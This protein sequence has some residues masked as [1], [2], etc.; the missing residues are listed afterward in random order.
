MRAGV[1]LAVIAA[2]LAGCEP[3]DRKYTRRHVTIP[4]PISGP[5]TDLA[6]IDGVLKP[7]GA[8]AIAADGA[9][10]AL[11]APEYY[12]GSGRVVAE[13]LGRPGVTTDDAGDTVSLNFVE[14]GILEVVDVVLSKTLGLN[15]VIDAR[16]QGTVTAR[17]SKPIPRSA[18]LAVLEN[19]LALNGAAM[20]EA[21]GVYNIVPVGAV[22]SLPKVVVTPSQRPQRQGVG[23]HVIPLEFASVASVRDIVASL[24]SPGHQLA[25]DHARNILIYTGPA[26]EARGIAEM[27]SVLDVDVLAGMSFALFP[28]QMS[29]ARDVAAELEMLFAEDAVGALGGVIR[30]LPIERLNAILAIASRPAH[31]KHAGEWVARLDRADAAA[32]QRV[33]V[34][35]AK[36]SRASD[37]TDILNQVFQGAPSRRDGDVRRAAVAPGLEPV[38]LI[39]PPRVLPGEDQSAGVETPAAAP[40]FA[41]DEP[42]G[43]GILPTTDDSTVRF[44]ADDRNNAV[45]VIATAEQ[46]GMIEATLK[47]LD[48]LPLQVLIEATIAEV[49]LKDELE[50]GLQWAFASGDFSGSALGAVALG[51]FAPAFPGFNLVLDTTDARVVLNAL[52]AVTD[53]EVISSPQLMVLDNQT[54]RLQVGDEVPILTQSS[55]ATSD[56]GA[57]IVNSI[58]YVDTG[59]IL[60]VTPRVNAGGLVTLDISLE[61]SDAVFTE[62]SIIG[63]PT[64]QQRSIQT[65]VAVQSG[66]TVALGGLIRER[67]TESVSGIPILMDIPLL[68]NLFKTTGQDMQRTELLVLITPRVVR[69]AAQ[70][71]A[72]TEE[73]R[74]RLTILQDVIALAE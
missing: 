57:P 69:G 51:D 68:G 70:A 66:E 40:A 73:L 2:G 21:E 23:I 18:V 54:A 55:I 64:I 17:T 26:Q 15:Y 61:V 46:F 67:S 38:E 14:T 7:A 1:V 39:A 60:E 42:P 30:F 36:N 63:S 5:G 24:V 33:F 20:V 12:Y 9:S 72:V 45:V 6:D 43:P 50:Y 62:S 59:V 35:F 71:R 49:A 13:P 8:Q 53:V 16:V 52:A 27:V 28:V 41:L 56:P 58:S 10:D 48:I 32:G 19:I 29:D 22:A 74:Q 4:A 31:L 37:L 25:V 34:Y 3:I 65:T 11:V 44:V 47:Q